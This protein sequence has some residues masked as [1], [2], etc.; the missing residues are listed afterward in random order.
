MGIKVFL[1]TNILFDVI[2]VSRKNS[3]NVRRLFYLSEKKELSFF[4]SAITVS[5]IIYVMQNKFKMEA[6][7]LKSRL[8]KLFQLV[9]VVP[10]DMEV[11]IDGLRLEFDDVEDSFQFVSALKCKS[12]YLVTEDRRFLQKDIRN[13]RI[14]VV[15]TEEFLN[16]M[17]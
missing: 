7:D 5:N 16:I 4:I 11:I 13:D 14:K 6:A 10:Y 1:D 12:D 2:D 3:S 9:D 15:N 8:R 17:L